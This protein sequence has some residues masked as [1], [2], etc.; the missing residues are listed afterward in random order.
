MRSY[1]NFI[2]K[3][4]NTIRKKWR[5]ELLKVCL[6]FPN[7]YEIGV[8]NLAMQILYNLWNL[9]DDVICERSFYNILPHGVSIESKRRLS[10]F[11][12]IAFTL[13]YEADIINALKMLHMANIPLDKRKRKEKPLVIAGGPLVIQNPRPYE[14]FFDALFIGEVE[15]VSDQLIDSLKN[16]IETNDIS[17]LTNVPGVYV[18]E[19]T[20]KVKRV[21]VANLD[22]VFYPTMQFYPTNIEVAFGPSFLLEISRGCGYACRFCLSGYIYRPFRWRSFKRIVEII[23]EGLTLTKLRKVSIIS[24]AVSDHPNIKN[25]LED[26]ISRKVMVSLPSLR[27]DKLSTDL[28]ALI[29]KCG[30]KTLTLAPEV[31]TTSLSNKINKRIYP[32]DVID[33]CKIARSIGFD[34]LKMYFI[35]GFSEETLKDVLEISNLLN[36]IAKLGFSHIS[37]T[38]NPLIPKPHTPLQWLPF[39]SKKEYNKKVKQIID[40]IRFKRVIEVRKLKWNEAFLQCVIA[41]SDN[42]LAPL[43]EEIVTKNINELSKIVKLFMHNFNYLRKAIEGYN[44]DEVLPWSVIDIGV[45]EKYLKK[46][47]EKYLSGEPT[48]SCYEK[49]THCGVCV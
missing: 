46:E 21:Y 44:I 45:S 33:L 23:E 31:A 32:D 30:Q 17:E 42:K 41:R 25:V 12:V 4:N 29:R 24:F 7:N 39:I 13:Q 2:I 10:D 19:Y 1:E 9:R 47:F 6:C 28:L 11:D 35:V 40:K 8:L 43:L 5:D 15:E 20:E 37:V 48:P 14:K 38:I 27:I 18:P 26:L 34:K 16:V 36:N 49:C 22:K 3:E